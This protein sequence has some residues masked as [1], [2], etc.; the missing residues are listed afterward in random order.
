MS[1]IRPS[2]ALEMHHELLTWWRTKYALHFVRGWNEKSRETRG[3]PYMDPH[4]RVE[5]EVHWL[6]ESPTYLVSK[7]MMALALHAAD[8]MELQFLQPEDLPAKA[9]LCILPEPLLLLDRYSKHVSFAAFSWS[10]IRGE[11][12]RGEPITGSLLTFYGDRFETRDDYNTI[13][14]PP[15]TAPRL[16]MVHERFDAFNKPPQVETDPEAAEWAKQPENK[17][18]VAASKKL[19]WQLPLCLWSLMGQTLARKVPEPAERPTRRRL[20]KAGSPLANKAITVIYLRHVREDGAEDTSPRS[21]EW[22]HRWVVSGHW[23]MQAYGKGRLERK[24]IWVMPFVKGPD[25]APLVLKE[26]VHVLAR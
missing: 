2:M 10:P 6:G 15:T 22:T 19:T 26:K 20:Q 11:N 25:D 17:E 5:H 8:S 4:D 13:C 24:R 23:K 9:G 21:V 18:V 16:V 3:L 7:D 14:P 1:E 12:E